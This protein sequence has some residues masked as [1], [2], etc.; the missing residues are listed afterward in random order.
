[1]LS[2]VYLSSATQLFNEVALQDLLR[3][4]RDNNARL[5]ITGLLL[6]KDGNFIQAL[7]GPEDAVR[8]LY[9][10]IARDP[11]HTGL[12][13]VVDETITERH[14]P[15]WSMGFQSVGQL[16]PDLPGFSSFFK[17]SSLADAFRNNPRRVTTFLLTFRDLMG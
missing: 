16:P 12:S 13:T 8:T 11:R 17:E 4:S 2:L 3:T 9:K 5:D 7:E 15:N 6:Y 1:M 10:K 14:F